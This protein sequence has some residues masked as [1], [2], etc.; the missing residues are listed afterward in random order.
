M[1]PDR[2]IQNARTRLEQRPRESV[3]IPAIRSGMDATDFMMPDHTRAIRSR[4][5]GQDLNDRIGISRS[6]RG[7]ASRI[8]RTGICSPPANHNH[9]RDQTAHASSLSQD[10]GIPTPT[11]A[12]TR[13]GKAIASHTQSSSPARLVSQRPSTKTPHARAARRFLDRSSP[14]A[15][16]SP[17]TFTFSL[18]R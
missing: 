9:P 8:Q 5:E 3:S 13:H 17:P 11:A 4:S 2:L 16:T 10:G 18:I 12:F 15:R 6:N 14:A 7:R 1:N